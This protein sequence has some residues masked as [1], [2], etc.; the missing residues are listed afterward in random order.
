MASSLCR[1]WRFT[2]TPYSGEGD[3]DYGYK[4]KTSGSANG[5]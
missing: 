5:R 4:K 2:E 1:E 3:D